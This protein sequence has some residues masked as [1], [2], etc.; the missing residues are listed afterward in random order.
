[1]STA[2][3]EAELAEMA[4]ILNEPDE[5]AQPTPVADTAEVEAELAEM[6]RILNEPDEPAQ[7]TPEA[8]TA[9]IEAELAEMAEKEEPVIY[10]EKDYQT[11]TETSYQVHTTEQTAEE[12]RQE[13]INLARILYGD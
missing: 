9:E 12:A 7:P 13:L 8:D 4:R 6:A 11:G 1:L 10:Y 5:P 3:V 2:E